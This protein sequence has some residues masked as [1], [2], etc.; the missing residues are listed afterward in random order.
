MRGFLYSHFHAAAESPQAPLVFVGCGQREF[1]DL[2]ALMVALFW[3]NAGL[4]VV[5]LGQDAGGADLVEQA[6]LRRPGLVALLVAD[7]ARVR[8][9]SRVARDLH[10]LPHPRP[11]VA[12]GGP[13]FARHP[14]LQRKVV[15][16]YL[17]DD[18]TTATWQVRRLLGIGRAT[19]PD[20]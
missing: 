10:A 17:G 16:I 12:F 11:I 4:R 8:A 14:E 6:R 5:Y 2:S 7:S 20:R 1:G 9:L 15:G 19:G 18:A 13:I 3:R